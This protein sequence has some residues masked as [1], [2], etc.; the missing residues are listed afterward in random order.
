MEPENLLDELRRSEL[1]SP[2]FPKRARYTRAEWALLPEDARLAASEPERLAL[3]R[4]GNV[5]A[6]A[7]VVRQLGEARYEPAVPALAALWADCA[8][9]PIRTAAGEALRAIGGPAARAMGSQRQ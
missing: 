9:A 4:L 7:E 6:I 8:L 2:D 1:F 3:G 5:H